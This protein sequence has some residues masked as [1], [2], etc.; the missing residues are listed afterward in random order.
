MSILRSVAAC[1][2]AVVA[3]AGCTSAGTDVEQPAPSTSPS[4]TPSATPTPAL[5]ERAAVWEVDLPG[6]GTFENAT[7]VGETVL[8]QAER[9]LVALNRTDGKVLWKLAVEG[10][11]RVSATTTSVVVED[12][13]RLQGVHL[14]T[15]RPRY[16][17]PRDGSSPDAAVT[18]GWVV[19]PDC[20]RKTCEA[21]GLR[22]PG[23]S[24]RWTYD[25]PR[26]VDARRTSPNVDARDSDLYRHYF[27]LTDPALVGPSELVVVGREIEGDRVMTALD[28]ATGN[29][30]RTFSA[31]GPTIVLSGSIGL[32]WD[33]STTGCEARLVAQDVRTGKQAWERDVNTWD[34][35][36]ESGYPLV[37]G[38]VVA[39]TTVNGKPTVI[40]LATGEVRWTGQLDASPMAL[41]DGTLLART[42]DDSRAESLVGLDLAD[43]RQRWKLD[44]PGTLL[45]GDRANAAVNGD[46]LAYTAPSTS[47]AGP[48]RV[49]NVHDALTGEALWIATGA[50]D[51]LGLSAQWMVTQAGAGRVQL[52]SSR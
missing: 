2:V 51:L 11:T 9:Q 30:G 25:F 50:D 14:R 21:V 17:R 42:G 52:F 3:V 38:K 46:R 22:L 4:A 20:A 16:Q 28:T 1:A 8:V 13:R 29:P 18:S 33:R 44:L 10:E 32:T 40:D 24:K 48:R 26:L 39:G 35:V 41:T 27:D 36:S 6:A 49:V 23:F 34:C 12:R 47:Q 15:G 5:A 7:V 19:V 45:V 43:G 37:D 31:L